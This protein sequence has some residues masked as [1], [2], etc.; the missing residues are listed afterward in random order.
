MNLVIIEISKLPKFWSFIKKLVDLLKH[1]KSYVHL[2]TLSKKE[3]ENFAHS[4]T[5]FSD[6]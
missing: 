1:F 5:E 2:C 4:D 6:T 3:I